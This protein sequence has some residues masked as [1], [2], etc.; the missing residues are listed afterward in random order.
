M[1]ATGIDSLT[2]CSRHDDRKDRYQTTAKTGNKLF[3]EIPIL[4]KS[5]W[6]S[7]TNNLFIFFNTIVQNLMH[8]L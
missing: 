2:C 8:C 5:E 6:E 3:V 7:I 1:I 4:I